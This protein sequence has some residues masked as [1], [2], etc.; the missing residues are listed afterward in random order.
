MNGAFLIGFTP[1][2]KAETGC[3]SSSFPVHSTTT[4]IAG[5]MSFFA[6]EARRKRWNNV[7]S[8]QRNWWIGSHLVIDCGLHEL[9]L[10]GS[11]PAGPDHRL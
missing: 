11:V 9:S 3:Q 8:H 2:K 5:G 6:A 7:N 4:G 10:P 1:L